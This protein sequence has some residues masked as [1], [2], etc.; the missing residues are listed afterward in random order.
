MSS[1]RRW[2]FGLKTL[3]V[4]LM[5][6]T[7]PLGWVG[8]SLNWIRERHEAIEHIGVNKFV[9]APMGLWIFGEDGLREVFDVIQI[10]DKQ[11]TREERKMKAAA[12]MRRLKRLFPEAEDV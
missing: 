6:L 2:S 12:A 11:E 7:G 10:T 1:P 4:W 3:L 8:Y 9:R 5:I